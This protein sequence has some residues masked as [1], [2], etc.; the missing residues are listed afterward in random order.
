MK[1]S[2]KYLNTI[3]LQMDILCEQNILFPSLWEIYPAK[4]KQKKQLFY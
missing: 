2:W 4:T 1:V 3:I